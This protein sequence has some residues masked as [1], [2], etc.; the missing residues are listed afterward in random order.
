MSFFSWL[1]SLF[2]KKKKPAPAP[3]PAPV[4]TPVP[5]KA[6]TFVENFAT[7]DLT[8]WS[9]LD[10]SPVVGD[11]PTNHASML[12]SN[13]FIANQMLC[14]RLTQTK[15][16]DGTFSSVGGELNSIQFFGFGTYE[17]VMKASSDSADPTKAGNSVS[18][19]ITG[20]FSFLA[21]SETEIDVEV[22]G[23]TRSNVAALTS[24]HFDTNPSET[25]SIVTTPT[26]SAA[27]H[28]YKYIWTVTDITFFIDGVQVAKHTKVIPTKPAQFCLNHYGENNADWGGTGTNGTRYMFVKSFAFTA[29]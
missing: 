25:E 22:E 13:C 23:G 4:P 1:A 11:G 20:A 14:I 15:N 21:N 26:P 19:S 7:L 17:F 16:A 29:A 8:K 18:G 3:T 12:A 10:G 28:T 6:P 5:V 27:F 2:G 9:M 24:W